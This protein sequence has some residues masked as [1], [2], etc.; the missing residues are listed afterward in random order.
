A[1]QA[2]AGVN[3]ERGEPPGEGFGDDQRA[4]VWGDDHA[5]GKLDVVCDLA[6]FP[7]AGEELDV[8]GLGRSPAGEVEIRAVDVGVAQF[9]HDDL[10]RLLF[11]HDDHR[12]VGLP[13][14][15]LVTGGQQPAV[16]KPVDGV[17]H[18]MAVGVPCQDDLRCAVHTDGHDLPVDPVAEPQ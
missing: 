14:L 11:G 7:V 18:W 2:P 12:S 5:V 1:G 16:G 3:I 10:V 13:A 6:N 15:N 9:V 8:A 17:T 4:S